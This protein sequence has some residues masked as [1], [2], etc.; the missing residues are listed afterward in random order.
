MKESTVNEIMTEFIKTIPA[1]STVMEAAKIMTELGIGSIV[2]VQNNK[3]IGMLTERDIVMKVVSLDLNPSQVFVEKIMSHPIITIEPNKIIDEAALVMSVYKIRRLVVVERDGK[4][5]GILTVTDI[6]S[7][8][9]RNEGYKNNFLN[10]IARL[11]NV[12]SVP[13]Q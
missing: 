12:Q 7:W 2:V 10:A 11:H 3:P 9:S 6:A 4:L 1:G 13:Y 5:L 8:L